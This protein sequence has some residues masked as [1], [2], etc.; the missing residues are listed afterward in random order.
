MPVPQAS[1]IIAA[2]GAGRR[3]IE[4]SARRGAGRAAGEA[5][6]VFVDLAGRPVLAHVLSAFAAVEPVVEA[7]VA[8][9]ADVVEW[10]GE[11]FGD[12]APEGRRLKFIAGGSERFDSV[13]LA[14]AASDRGTELVAIHD[15]VRPLIRPAVIA[16][17]LRVA[18]EYGAAVVGRPLDHTIKTVAKD[19]RVAETVPRRGLWMAQT[20]QVFRRE[21][22]SQA[23][24][25]RGDMVGSVTDDAQ[26]VEAMG[27]T[28][29]MVPG[30]AANLKIT[31][32][33]DLR[34]CEAIL[35]AGWPFET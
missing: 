10:A 11:T 15:G 5:N 24:E 25:R 8:V 22:I 31:T 7:I 19:G 6:K 4:A 34:V 16:E 18:V 3:F 1:V 33:E 9:S 35:A 27:Q 29:M 30:D 12:M 26:L 21:I 13:A 32:P 28:V 20:P 17:A 23:Y 14:L 2:A